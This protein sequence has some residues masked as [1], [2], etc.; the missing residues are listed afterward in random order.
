MMRTPIRLDP[1]EN[2]WL[3]RTA[4]EHG[5]PPAAVAR[6]AVARRGLR[7]APR[8]AKDFAAARFDF[9]QPRYSV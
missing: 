2:A 3:D 5:V 4:R 7:P 6:A 8:T 1:E 9:V